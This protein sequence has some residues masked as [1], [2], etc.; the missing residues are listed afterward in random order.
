MYDPN[1][2]R[3]RVLSNC[4]FS[5]PGIRLQF[6]NH[7]AKHF[8][9]KGG[10]TPLRQWARHLDWACSVGAPIGWRVP[11]PCEPHDLTFRSLSLETAD[12]KLEIVGLF[13]DKQQAADTSFRSS[14]GSPRAS[15]DDEYVENSGCS[16]RAEVL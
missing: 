8:C 7:W 10:K 14:G 12:P 6:V 5:N 16:T 9:A 2:A 3:E 15:E 4:R 11:A 1:Q 13:I